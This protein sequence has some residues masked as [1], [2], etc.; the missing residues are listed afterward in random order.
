MSSRV[1]ECVQVCVQVCYLVV[2]LVGGVVFLEPVGQ[3]SVFE[4]SGDS[5]FHLD[6]PQS[7]SVGNHLHH[8]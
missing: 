5:M 4:G 6:L 1:D 3:W 7:V 2:L 8:T